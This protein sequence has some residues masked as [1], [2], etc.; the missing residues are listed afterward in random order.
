VLAWTVFVGC[1]LAPFLILINKKIK[2]M[3][4]AMTVICLGVMAGIWLE[5][6]LLLGPAFHHH[7]HHLPLGWVEVAVAI[8]FFGLLAAAVTSYFKHFPE[9]LNNTE[10]E[11][12]KAEGV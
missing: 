1:F 10:V 5:H 11:S 7:A 2:T 6:Y 8:G 4:K 9:L 3:P 12:L